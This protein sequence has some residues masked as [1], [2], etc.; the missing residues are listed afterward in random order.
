[1]T[2]GL[3][4]APRATRFA[5]GALAVAAVSDFLQRAHKAADD[6]DE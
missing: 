2:A 5:S 6:A 3:V 1:M 4:V